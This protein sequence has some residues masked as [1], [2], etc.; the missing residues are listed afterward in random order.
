M[1]L[2]SKE[3]GWTTEYIFERTLHEINWRLDR[4][5]KRLNLDRKFEMAIHGMKPIT[6]EESREPVKLDADQEK[7]MKIA[8]DR[9]KKRKAEEFKNKG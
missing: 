2:F 6:G 8:L 1:D 5:S 9:A 7:A 3:Y 4:I